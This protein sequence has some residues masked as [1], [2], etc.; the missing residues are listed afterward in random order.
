M[1]DLSN[2]EKNTL[3]KS[4]HS[5]LPSRAVSN[6][7]RPESETIS[8]QN[9]ALPSTMMAIKIETAPSPIYIKRNLDAGLI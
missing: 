1:E 2:S 6:Y 8:P 5:P 4:S 7:S 3:K 9:D